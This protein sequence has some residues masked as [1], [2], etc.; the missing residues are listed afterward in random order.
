MAT[1]NYR[2]APTIR[3]FIKHFTPG[4]LFS[5]WIIGPVGSGKT[6]GIFMKLVYMSTLQAPSPIDGKRRVRAV[7][8]RNTM[9]QLKDTTITSW[10]YWFKEGEA[11]KWN[12]TDKNFT[13]KF[14]D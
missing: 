6:T 2:P 11:G 10:S 7:I 1:I 8:V 12:A 5:D 3:E 14:A 9:P 13:L 4:K